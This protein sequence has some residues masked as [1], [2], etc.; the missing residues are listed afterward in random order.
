MT[1]NNEKDADGSCGIGSNT[2]E[3]NMVQCD[4]CNTWFC[5]ECVHVTDS[6]ADVP[7]KCDACKDKVPKDGEREQR[8]GHSGMSEADKNSQANGSSASV[9]LNS[10]FM[11]LEEQKRIELEYARKKFELMNKYSLV[12]SANDRK[13]LSAADKAGALGKCGQNVDGAQC[14]T[15]ATVKCSQSVGGARC[16]TAGTQDQKYSLQAE[17]IRARKAVPRELPSFTGN[18]EECK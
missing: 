12:S 11:F 13:F 18:P 1:D 6:V 14:N 16:D 2:R 7:W 8:V 17:Q 3:E 5:Y 4:D 9:H 10:E 15:G